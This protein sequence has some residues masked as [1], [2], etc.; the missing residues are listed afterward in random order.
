MESTEQADCWKE[1]GR[2]ADTLQR[3][4]SFPEYRQDLIDRFLFYELKQIAT[5]RMRPFES[6]KESN[7]LTLSCLSF[8]ARSQMETLRKLNPV[9]ENELREHQLLPLK[10]ARTEEYSIN[11][12]NDCT[13]L[14]C[15]RWRQLTCVSEN[16][17]TFIRGL[18]RQF[19][20]LK[21]G[22]KFKMDPTPNDNF[23]TFCSTNVLTYKSLSIWAARFLIFERSRLIFNAMMSEP[24]LE[25]CSPFDETILTKI[26]KWL[27]TIFSHVTAEKKEQLQNSS[28]KKYLL[29][30]ED[31][32]FE[33]CKNRTVPKDKRR[34]MKATRTYFS[35]PAITIENSVFELFDIECVVYNFDDWQHTVLIEEYE[36]FERTQMKFR[37]PVIIKNVGFY[38]VYDPAANRYF[39]TTNIFQSFFLWIEQAERNCQKYFTYNTQF[40]A[41]LQKIKK[42]FTCP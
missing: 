8:V 21:N 32:F 29:P 28:S 31:C 24:N 14:L 23:T 7:H 36:F 35:V 34:V 19:A 40:C 16:L 12:I 15:L 1:V 11:D 33:S 3:F 25:E 18:S 37:I 9:D 39:Q 6:R 20:I 26:K 10:H 22:S 38:F 4:Y 41:F 17:F 42:V 13:L 30:S 27:Q 5:F 2:I